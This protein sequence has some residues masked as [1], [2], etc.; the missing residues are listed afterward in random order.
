MWFTNILVESTTSVFRMKSKASKQWSSKQQ[1]KCSAFCLFVLLPSL[2]LN[3]EDEESTFLLNTGKHLYHTT[4]H[5]IP[6]DN[7]LQENFSCYSNYFVIRLFSRKEIGLQ[8]C[9]LNLVGTSENA[10]TNRSL[11]LFI[12]ILLSHSWHLIICPWQVVNCISWTPK[13]KIDS[14]AWQYMIVHRKEN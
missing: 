10:L 4:W 12:Q 9:N 1:W 11:V 6:K 5:H 2:I 3:A 8:I 7:N 14:H 13:K